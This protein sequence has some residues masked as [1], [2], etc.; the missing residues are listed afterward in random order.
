[1][2]Y[3]DVLPVCPPSQATSYGVH[4]VHNPPT[5]QAAGAGRTSKK[6]YK[7]P[8][9]QRPDGTVAGSTKRLASRVSQLKTG[10]CRTG[11]YLHWA[12]V[13]PTLQCWWC[14]CPSQTR[15]H[16]FKVC[17]E[18]N[19]QQKILWAEVLKETKRWKSRWTVRDLLADE[20]CGQAVLDFLPLRMWEDW[21]RRLKKKA[22]PEVRSLSGS[23]GSAEGG[24]R[25]GWQRR[26]SWE[27]RGIWV[28]GGSHRCSCPRLPS[29]HPQARSRTQG[30]VSFVLP[31]VFRLLFPW[32]AS[33]LLGTG[34]GGGQR[35]ACNVPPLRG[36]RTGKIG[37]NVHRHDLDR[38]NAS[39]VKQK[40]KNTGSGCRSE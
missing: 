17:P 19:M 35:G 6:K 23:S 5:P 39:M 12:K 25:S 15:D 29:W 16:L 24:K 22:S 20:R 21:C 10:H 27:P 8:K 33:H 26:R 7:M 38:L 14:Q 2:C 40:K 36:Q 9:S 11:Q 34:L 1:M 18:W 32:C 31:F 13:R 30:T 28:M 37:Q 4:T 3:D